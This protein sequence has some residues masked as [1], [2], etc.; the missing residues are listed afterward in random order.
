MSLMR[1]R[2]KTSLV[3]DINRPFEEEQHGYTPEEAKQE[4]NRCL[5]CRHEPCVK[6]CVAN[7]PIP[8]IIQAIKEDRNEDAMALIQTKG[9][10]PRVCS[11]VCFH[12]KQCEG[13]CVR[14]IRGEPIGIGLLERFVSDSCASLPQPILGAI[15]KDRVAIIGSGPSGLACAKD[16]ADEGYHV[17]I[18]EA[19]ELG[20]G[21]LRY[22][23]PAYRLPTQIVEE[24]IQAVVNRGVIMHYC[25]Q[26]GKDISFDELMASFD[27]VYL[28]TGVG[29]SHK[30]NIPGD[31]YPEVISAN[32]FLK[33]INDDVSHARSDILKLVQGKRVRI[34]GGGNVAMDAARSAIRLKAKNVKIL[35]R[36]GMDELPARAEEVH[37]ALEEK[38]AIL[39]LLSP[40]EIIGEN[41]HVTH[42]I[43][44]Q[45]E[46]SEEM[47]EG[48]RGIVAT[49]KKVK[50]KADLIIEAIGGAGAIW[51]SENTYSIGV[52]KQGY[53]NVGLNQNTNHEKVFAGGDVVSGAL[54]V[55]HAMKAGRAGAKAI[56]AYLE[57]KN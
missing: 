29:M 41:G 48:R 24:E 14:G 2:P 39:T 20:G 47:Q 19:S 11:R 22:G 13:S 15:K 6:G 40:H 51:L 1:V 35:Y 4:A 36:R 57:S 38:V 9:N 8:Q 34:V 30:L 17:E 31:D 45:N 43:C 52:T 25:T 27:A 44:T 23:I 49:S 26:V 50:L 12:E 46:L 54:T 28:A 18:F 32:E 42:I 55:V 33:Y 37:E 56:A 3:C 16:L 53:I 7:L 21:V 5:Q 10:L